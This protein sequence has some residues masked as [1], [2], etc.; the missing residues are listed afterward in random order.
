MALIFSHSACLPSHRPCLSE[1]RVAAVEWRFV[2][3]DSI[4][5]DIADQFTYSQQ[6]I[7]ELGLYVCLVWLYMCDSTSGLGVFALAGVL[8]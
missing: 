2:V 3:L 4:V 1:A 5:L 6:W 8:S 7:L